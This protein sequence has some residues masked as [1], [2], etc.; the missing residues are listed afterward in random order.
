MLFRSTQ[1]FKEKENGSSRQDEH[2][3]RVKEKHYFPNGKEIVVCYDAGPLIYCM[4]SIEDKS[5]YDEEL[6]GEIEK[7]GNYCVVIYKPDRF[8]EKCAVCF[9][10]DNSF[11]HQ[12]VDYHCDDYFN[13]GNT[14]ALFDKPDKYRGQH[15]YRF[16]SSA[17]H[18]IQVIQ[19][20]TACQPAFVQLRRRRKNHL[21]GAG[22][23]QHIHGAKIQ[24]RRCAHNLPI[25][26]S[27]DRFYRQ[28]EAIFRE[29][30][31]QE[32]KPRVKNS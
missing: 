21:S 12:K 13:N 5:D 18:S 2:E 7:L 4:I 30:V 15:E 9:K 3:G 10:K 27:A 6:V 22:V 24:E 25:R 1:Y 17:L 8:I 11:K 31:S 23:R 19:G 16:L 29:A 14:Y 26:Q 32:I 28:A 20:A